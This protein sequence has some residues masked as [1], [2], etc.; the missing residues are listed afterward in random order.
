MY[1]DLNGWKNE[2]K[3]NKPKMMLKSMKIFRS[4]IVGY[5]LFNFL[6]NLP[7]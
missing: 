7:F 5:A 1:T 2:K 6:K 3:T 4:F